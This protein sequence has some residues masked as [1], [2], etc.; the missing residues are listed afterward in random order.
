MRLV[1]ENEIEMGVKLEIREEDGD[2]RFWGLGREQVVEGRGEKIRV[3]I[4]VEV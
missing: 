4:E 2:E 1:L 3:A